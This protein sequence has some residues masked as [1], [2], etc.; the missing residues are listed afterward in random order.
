M[1]CSLQPITPFLQSYFNG[2]QLPIPHVVVPFSGRE[3]L[4]DEGA[5]MEFIV[6]LRSLGEERPDSYVRGI[7]LNPELTTN[8]WKCEDR[9]RS[10]GLL[11][12]LEGSLSR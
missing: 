8:V 5:W 3:F 6:H 10:K 9:R 7:Y 11:Q 1:L 12:P 2:Q 4:R